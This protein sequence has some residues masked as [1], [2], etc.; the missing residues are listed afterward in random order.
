MNHSSSFDRRRLLKGIGQIATVLASGRMTLATAQTKEPVKFLLDWTWWP[1]QIPLIV[2][3]EKGY[4][5][6]AGLDV[7]FRQGT[8]SGTT[9]QVVGQG[10]YDIGHVNLTAAAQFIAKGVPIKG[11]AT[12]S[13]KGASGLVFKEGAIKG[14]KDLI[15]KRIGST[16]GGS[17]SQ[18]LPAFFAKN[19]IEPS[20]VTLVNLPGDAKLGALLTGQI[21][22]LSGD[23]YYYVAL[24]AERG[25][26]LGQLV[27]ADYQANTIGYGLIS[28]ADF[29][30]SHPDRIKRFVA[31]ALE[32]YLYAE[33][34]LDEAIAIYK[35]V[36]KTEQSN[37]TIRD[38]LSG[39][40]SLIRSGMPS[41]KAYTGRNEAAT[42][43]GTIDVLTRYGGLSSTKDQSE[44]WTNDFVRA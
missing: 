29:I 6:K 2:A 23:G 11:I 39:Y 21:D 28:S 42:W 36:S 7:E 8:G 22:V 15:G 25:V 14:A 38:I 20:Q 16:S 44:Y 24:A 17:D 13:Q 31:A 19:S 4:F 10:S 26:K 37:A 34:N 32:G 12:I 33:R 1:P 18:I 30:K 9:C 43:T 35:Q 5:D 40:L 41:G 3:R 27:F